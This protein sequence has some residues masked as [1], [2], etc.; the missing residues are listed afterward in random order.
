[1]TEAPTR[2]YSVLGMDCAAC[3]REVEAGVSQ[4]EGVAWAEVNFATGDMRVQ[5]D[6][7]FAVLQARVEALGK[8]L[9]EKAPA[10]PPARG[11]V[12]GFWD[13]LRARA[14]TRLALLGGFIIF[15]ALAGQL[16]AAWPSAIADALYSVGMVVALYPIAKSGLQALVLLRRFNINL[17]MSI[18]ALGAIA[19][20]EYLESATVIFLF[21]IGEA[22][23]G[24]TA[25]RARS[26]IRGLMA[27]RPAQALRLRDG[28]ETWV[29]VEA[30][31]VGDILLIKP[32][33]RI[34]MDAQ[35]LSGHSGVNQAPITGESA[36]V[37]KSAGDA[38]YA[39]TLNGEG[40]L[41]VRVTRLAHD[42]TISR[43]IQ[44]VEEAQSQRAPTQRQIDRFA[45]Y[46]TPA[47]TLLAAGVAVLPPL[48]GGAPFYDWLYR[49][50]A[51]LV[52]ACPCAL[53]IS[54]PVTVMSALAAAAR[55][56]ALIKG[57]AHLE[58]LAGLRAVAFDKTG[59]LT[60]G[61][62]ALTTTRAADCR[63]DDGCPSC[64]DV[65][66]LA[67]ALERQTTHPLGRAVVRAAQAR[68][69]DSAYTAA[70]DV[71]VLAGRGIRGRVGDRWVTAGSHAFFD[72]AFPHT[73]ALCA[74]IASAEAAGQTTLLLA[75]GDRV[76]GF[77]ALAD[78]PRDTSAAVIRELRALGIATVLLT[79]DNPQAAGR[80]AAEIG[81]D[82]VR[83]ELLPSDKVRAVQEMRARYG[84]V[85]MV[86]DGI[87]DT[88]AL[89]AATVG[90]A[91]GGAG[92][93]QALEVAD[94]ALMSDDLA[95]LPRVIRLARQ[96]RGIISQNIA[97]S[98]G[99]KALFL[100]L[101]FW[102]ATSLWLAIAA[103][104]GMSL[105]VTLNG[106]RPLRAAR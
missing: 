45:H 64:A 58:A 21:A 54:T 78:R 26:S 51:M 28:A 14:E 106:M 79:G 24:Y 44:L 80:I 66:A 83:A 48:I 36:P 6:V 9:A 104:V 37:A 25:E 49:A 82:D 98:L 76:R 50:L 46:Y 63:T 70:A 103:D 13:Y 29:P 72:E 34:P 74:D 27:L 4:L 32:G 71:E 10:P 75:E 16:A 1:M 59:T 86:G 61:E 93:P 23:E 42:N 47:V 96:T 18:A 43:I 55:H 102:G 94:I 95:Q 35:V 105:A 30:L 90:I 7:P 67:S 17:L 97:L 84:A 88:P 15:I 12:R 39:G 92:S 22:L 89:A 91:M 40:L 68:R 99:L 57:G 62:L 100:L 5:G 53:V 31:A 3:A 101:A 33:E 19:L 77:I 65:L 73:A 41:T 20:G 69:L 52:I 87:N 81:L 85:A 56:G 38:V 8:G 11:G 60:A 2:T